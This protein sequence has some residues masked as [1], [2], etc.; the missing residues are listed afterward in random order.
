MHLT[1]AD[2]ADRRAAEQTLRGDAAA[3]SHLVE[4]Y[5][6]MVFSCALGITRNRED[7]A[8]AAQETFVRLYRHLDQ[9]D[10]ERPLKPYLMTIAVNCA[11]NIRRKHRPERST[12]DD[13]TMVGVMTDDSPGPEHALLSRE[14]RRIVRDVIDA[15]P[16][17]LRDVCVLFYLNGCSCRETAGILRTSEGAVRVALHRAREKLQQ[18]PLREWASP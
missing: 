4:T 13:E 15:L 18:S 16:A 6:S 17:M 10:L 3:F 8:D 9:F 7:A 5:Q 1:P 12:D 2:K 11:R 14:R